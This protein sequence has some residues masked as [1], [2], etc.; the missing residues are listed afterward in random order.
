MR[1]STRRASRHDRRMVRDLKDYKRIIDGTAVEFTLNI[2]ERVA[3]C[4]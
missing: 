4:L 1:D 2:I 3:M